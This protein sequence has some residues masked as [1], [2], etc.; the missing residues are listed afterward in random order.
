MSEWGAKTL[1][2]ETGR[3]LAEARALAR[4]SHSIANQ[5]APIAS[6]SHLTCGMA[7]VPCS[8]NTLAAL[9]QGRADNLL[10]RAADVT[11]KERRPLVAVVRET[12][13]SR[14]HIRNMLACTEAGVTVMPPMPAFYDAP[15]DLG[16]HIDHFTGRLLDQFGIAHSLGSRWR[17]PRD[18]APAGGGPDGSQ[19]G[20]KESS[21]SS[22]TP[23]SS[24]EA[25][26]STSTTTL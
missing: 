10:L 21:D 17:A 3:T 1:R 19:A 24:A 8:V 26:R 25:S 7:I 4:W 15:R 11:L 22:R 6:G 9:A 5:A 12:P 20:S 13:L 23:T 14:T 16:A 18:P 2:M